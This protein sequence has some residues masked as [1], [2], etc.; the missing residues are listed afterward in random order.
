MTDG[1]IG[2][3]VDT[4]DITDMPEALGTGVLLFSDA[5]SR[6][7]HLMRT[8]AYPNDTTRLVYNTSPN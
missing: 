6:P 8:T 7:R 3:A 1:L 2:G 4:V 5:C